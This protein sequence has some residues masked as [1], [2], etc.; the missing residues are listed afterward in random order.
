[1]K[2]RKKALAMIKEDPSKIELLYESLLLDDREFVLEACKAVVD[3]ECKFEILE[4]ANK[5]F[6]NDK[7]VVLAAVKACGAS[8]LYF[9]DE[10]LKKDK[11][12]VLAAVKQS[13][14]ALQDA[15]NSFKKDREIVLAAV[16]ECGWALDYADE[17]LQKDREIVIAAIKNY[18]N[19][20]RYA[21]KELQND[22]ELKKLAEVKPTGY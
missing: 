6:R 4:N 21:S 1:M 19:A 2:D 16:K 11:E 17:S 15:D 22:P 20:L 8:N 14:Y 3:H 7:E 18:G 10:S 5:S 12:I 9:A 13:G